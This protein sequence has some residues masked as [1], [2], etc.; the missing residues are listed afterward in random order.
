MVGLSTLQVT[1]FRSVARSI[2]D[3]VPDCP[4]R[5][6]YWRV[7]TIPCVRCFLKVTVG[8]GGP[9]GQTDIAVAVCN[10]QRYGRG[11]GQETK[12]ALCILSLNM[13][14]DKVSLTIN[15]CII[16]CIVLQVFA[17]LWVWHCVLILAGINRIV[18]RS[19]QLMSNRV[20]YFLMKMMMHR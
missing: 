10:Y 16:I 17:I 5:R 15:T 14:N 2:T 20:R 1:P 6:G 19:I 12:G 13:I 4:R 18:T 11:G 9:D 8:C 3:C 7:P